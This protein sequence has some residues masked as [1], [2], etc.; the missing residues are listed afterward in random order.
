MR[1]AALALLLPAVALAQS[2]PDDELGR[3][4]SESPATPNASSRLNRIIYLGSATESGM[5]R[6]TLDVPFPPPAPPD[7]EQ[8]FLADARLEWAVANEFSLTLAGRVEL[9]A[10]DGIPFPT[11]ENVRVDL[12]ELFASWRPLEGVFLDA[13]RINLKSGVAVGYNPTDFFRTRAVVEPLSI[14]PSVL[15]EDRLGAPMVRGQFVWHGGAV[16]AAYAPKL[17]SPSRLYGTTTLPSVNPMVD[18]TNAHH[19]FLLKGNVD[20]AADFSPELLF[21]DEDGQVRFGANLTRSFGKQIVAYAEWA[22]GRQSS[23]GE[24]AL[25]YG[26]L[27]GSIPAAVAASSPAHF[28]QDLSG[29]LSWSTESR[30]T[31]WI[32]YHLHQAGFSRQDWRSWFDD[33]AARPGFAPLLWYVRGYAQDQQVPL[34]RHGLFLRADWTDAFVLNLE[35]TAFANVNL[36]DGSTLGQLT[37]SYAVT[38]LWTIAL[39]GAANVGSRRSE[40]GSL[41][42]ALSVLL[43]IKRYF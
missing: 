21:Y 10:A 38:Y 33:G 11:H 13:G 25:A 16:T 26:E 39:L 17:T 22:G 3:I 28:Q 7:I 18:R 1:A 20:F 4:P 27:T 19:R 42:T 35:L 24:E 14:D 41:P 23:V 12:R 2:Q 30:I 15:R 34:S 6:P 5:S 9:R 43:S 8:R 40:F 29:G 31:F 36:L 37:A 32:E